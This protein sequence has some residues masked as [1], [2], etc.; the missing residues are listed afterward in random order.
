MSAT[1]ARQ[2]KVLGKCNAGRTIDGVTLV[3]LVL[4]M[5]GALVAVFEVHFPSH[6]LLGGLGVAAMSV[7]AV[8][9]IS[10]LG[11]GAALGLLGGAALAGAGF[12]VLT[13]S[14]MKGAAVRQR[15]IRT[16]VEA[17]VGRVGVV[18]RWTG[19]AGT[20]ALDGAVWHARRSASA[21]EDEDRE[22]H[23]GDYVVVERLSGLTLR[24][25]PAEEWELM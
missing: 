14:V 18:R 21:D 25:R 17:I 23:T 10:G 12:S 24:V 8:L 9:A 1:R 4:L 16:G 6:G 2:P 5:V 20:V 7:G 3:G 11:A 22:L 19:P 13:L 15:R